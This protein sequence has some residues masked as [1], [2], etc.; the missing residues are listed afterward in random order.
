MKITYAPSNFNFDN[1]D[2]DLNVVLYGHA[3]NP[4][5]GS[6]GAA[7]KKLILRRKLLPAPRA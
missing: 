4:T 5:Y 3:D 2:S 1:T 7:L 6:V